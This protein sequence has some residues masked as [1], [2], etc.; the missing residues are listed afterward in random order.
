MKSWLIVWCSLTII[1][2][3][4]FAQTSR[5]AT[6]RPLTNSPGDVKNGQDIVMNVEKSLCLLCH[7]LKNSQLPFQGT[8]APELT[9]MVQ[10]LSAAEL[11]FRLIDSTRINPNTIMPPYYRTQ[12]LHQ[13]AKPYRGK[14]LLSA[15]EIEDVVA[16]LVRL[17]HEKKP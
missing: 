6:S 12:G 5:F 11:R 4:V 3:L 7:S 8:I 9:L 2:Q 15:Q 13:V 17:S 14:T 1:S 16:Y 10:D